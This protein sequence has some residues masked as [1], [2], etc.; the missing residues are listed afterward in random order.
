MQMLSRLKQWLSASPAATAEVQTSPADQPAT[1]TDGQISD[2]WFASH[3]RYAADV[4]H[5]ALSPVLDPSAS[6][7]LDFGCYDGI[8]GL[9]LM[10]RHGWKRVIGVDIDPGFDALPRLAREQIRLE[11]LP[12]RLEFRRIAPNESLA[13][14]GRV[15]AVMSWSV[16]EHVERSILDRVVAD[17][18]SVL[19]PG[20][21]C[22]LQVD[23]LFFS[24]QGSHLGRF[25]TAPWAHLRMA[26]DELERFVM[27]AA[28]GTVPADEITEQFRSM[29]FDEYKRFIFRHYRELNRVTADELVALFTRNGFSLVWEKRRRTTESIPDDLA[30]RFDEDLLRTCEILALF[31]STRY[32]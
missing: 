5:D 32:A 28:P 17:F 27:A 8:T 29:S 12:S 13:P 6:S 4:V 25:A 7:L 11:R 15:D 22:F 10:L 2:E 18:H 19:A 24:P 16:F 3:F 14:T 20:G 23:P 9:G 21:H 31:R 30:G 1:W 26:D